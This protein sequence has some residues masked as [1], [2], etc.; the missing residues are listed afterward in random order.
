MNQI[1]TQVFASKPFGKSTF[2][3]VPVP[4]ILGP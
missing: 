4:V 1:D 2:M 3:D